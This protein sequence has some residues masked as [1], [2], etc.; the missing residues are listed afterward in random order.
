MEYGSFNFIHA[1]AVQN[2]PITDKLA[3]RAGVNIVKRDGYQSIGS[4]ADD[5]IAVRLSALYKPTTDTDIF[6]WG[7][8][9]K[10]TGTP[11]VTIILP[12]LD[13][14]DP[15]FVPTTDPAS[16]LSN[17][18]SELN[19]HYV[20][21]GADITHRFGDVELQYLGSY[22]HQFEHSVSKVSGFE[23]KNEF[24]QTEITHELKVS[25]NIAD[26]VDILGGAS[27]FHAQSHHLLNFGPFGTEFP[28]IL[29]KSLSA[30]SQATI[31]ITPSFRAIVGGRY[32]S[33]RLYAKG[34][35][36]SPFPGPALAI[37]YDNTRKHV[38]WKGSV[39]YDLTN[40]IMLYATAQSGYAPGTF[41]TF[42]DAFALD[43]EVQPQSLVSFSGG[44]KARLDDGRFTIGLEVY[45]AKYKSFIV[46]TIS[47]VVHLPALFNMPTAEVYGLQLNTSFRPTDND[48][49]DVN[50]AY[51]H[52]RYG[53]FQPDPAQADVGGLQ[54]QFTPDYTGTISYN[55]RFDVAN[56]GTVDARIATYLT[57]SYW[58]TFN[59][60]GPTKQKGYGKS[61]ASLTYKPQSG[62]WSAGVWVKNL[63]DTIV[64]SSASATGPTSAVAFLEPPREYGVTLKFSY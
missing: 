8:Y 57:S 21:S 46:Q 27:Y 18:G 1:E 52:G 56:G 4:Q 2:V 55:H 38:D 24:T 19:Y 59:H 50:F 48:T 29:Q 28:K 44:V 47:R 34:N 33:D 13:K 31:K 22:L 16:G 9:F 26:R 35:P 20:M 62:T 51:T 7:N 37:N 39:E 40:R 17:L 11:G 32:T 12:F 6:L 3:V 30:Y 14:N 45:D 10:N 25:A 58:G 36:I 42:A 60:E 15:Y 63:E 53:T 43:K 61:D 41:N 23:Q 5:S 49:L 54:M 64:R